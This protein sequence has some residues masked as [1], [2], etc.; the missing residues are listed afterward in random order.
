MQVFVDTPLTEIRNIRNESVKKVCLLARLVTKQ[1]GSALPADKVFQYEKNV[2]P[3][4]SAPFTVGFSQS[5]Q[6]SFI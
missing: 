5:K 4:L 6:I 2:Q 3:T 1:T